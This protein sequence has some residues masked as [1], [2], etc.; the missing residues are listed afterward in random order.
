M[1]LEIKKGKSINFR[2]PLLNEKIINV[3]W[4]K[5]EQS[6][7]CWAACTEMIL[8]Y[9][10]KS[11]IQQC[12]L[13]NELFN[14]SECCLNPASRK[15]NKPCDIEAVSNLYSR[16]CIHSEFVDKNV[17]FSK[18]Q[19]E[20]DA[21]RPIEVFLSW[22]NKKT[23]HLVIIRGWRIDDKEEFVHVNDPKDSESGASRIMTYSELLNNYDGEGAWICTWTGIRR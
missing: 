21:D 10:G 13:A 23:G 6:N 14:Q 16:K 2:K 17:P 19:S 8:R 12:E 5:Q 3:P 18:L 1:S 4:I 20:L 11:G 7:W 9:Y 22:K 15:C